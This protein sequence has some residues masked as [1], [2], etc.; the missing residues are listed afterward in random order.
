MSRN[1]GCKVNCAS[2][3]SAHE[4]SGDASGWL[5]EASE[6]AREK[7]QR[8]RVRAAISKRQ[9]ASNKKAI[10]HTCEYRRDGQQIKASRLSEGAN[11]ASEEAS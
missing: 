5:E 11:S 1:A 7:R 4:E 9:S 2:C 8:K 10:E 6:E 3:E